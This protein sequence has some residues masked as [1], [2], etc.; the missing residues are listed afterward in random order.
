MAT[1]GVARLGGRLGRERRDGDVAS[2]GDVPSEQR[3]PE[4]FVHELAP[5]IA[6]KPENMFRRE[7]RM[8]VIN[9]GHQLLNGLGSFTLGPK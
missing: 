5:L 7:I 9:L 6:V 1:A 4:R 2:D 8:I 3:R